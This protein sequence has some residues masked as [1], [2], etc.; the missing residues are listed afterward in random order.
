M[1]QL[2][3]KR[4]LVK[5]SGE[6]LKGDSS[7]GIDGAILKHLVKQVEGLVQQGCEVSLVVGGG[8]IFRGVSG[9]SEG[10][11]RADA[12]YMG[13]LA[14]VMNAIA[15]R[16]AFTYAGI[17][18]SIISALTMPALS[19]AYCR[20]HCLAHMEQ[21]T[22]LIFAAG[23]GNPFFTTDTAATLRAAEMNCDAVIKLTKVDGV[24]DKD[25][26]KDDTA[27][28]FSEL[29]FQDVLVNNY[30]VMDATAIA[31]ARD[32]KL[33]ILV[34]SFSEEGVLKDAVQGKGR[35]T[36]IKED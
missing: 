10:L 34:G 7:S 29:T 17:K 24:Y 4:V 22:V 33:P 20:E 11:E 16:G 18:T 3:Y 19:E 25:P 9:A 32:R 8:N 35:F 36:I 27:K 26:M 2:L 6:S 15:L 21:G 28:R 31:L 23:T 14:T 30:A 12:D 1:S 13:M 5:L